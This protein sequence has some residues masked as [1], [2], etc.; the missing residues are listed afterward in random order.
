[1][2]KITEEI[3]KRISEAKSKPFT[4]DTWWEIA[5]YAV[6]LLSC[7]IPAIII[8][9]QENSWQKASLSLIGTLLLIATIIILYRPIRAATKFIPGV[10]PFGAF[11]G[12]AFVFKTMADALLTIGIA[13]LVGSI[14]AIPLHYKYLSTQSSK[15]D[16]S[17][18]SLK[19]IAETLK[20]MTG[21]H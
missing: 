4:K 9:Y 17:L 21:Q 16:E 8:M 10:I 12:I 14:I 19:E 2:S 15:A 13:G 20:S 1:M 7:A 18:N 3:T 11:V 5:A 6:R